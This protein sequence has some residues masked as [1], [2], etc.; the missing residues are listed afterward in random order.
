MELIAVLLFAFGS[1]GLLFLPVR[2]IAA[3]LLRLP[4]PSWRAFV[5]L[6]LLAL[7][8]TISGAM[9]GVYTAHWSQA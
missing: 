2:M 8:A 4:R 7:I 5:L 3:I 1:S 9:L 6:L